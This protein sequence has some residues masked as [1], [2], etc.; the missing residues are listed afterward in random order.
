[1]NP[2]STVVYFYVN[3]V[4]LLAFHGSKGQSVHQCV[5]RF[6]HPTR[7]PPCCE[8]AKGVPPSHYFQVAF[9]QF[10]RRLAH[11]FL[12]KVDT[13]TTLS[14]K[15]CLQAVRNYS[16]VFDHLPVG[17]RVT[18]GERTLGGRVV[19]NAPL[20]PH[21]NS[22]T[23]SQIGGDPSCCSYLDQTSINRK[24]LTF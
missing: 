2:Y 20:K 8:I 7:Q 22:L 12:E 17:P 11:S 24:A 4:V 19:G 13:T 14:V 1:M 3:I 16:L 10:K 6:L 23:P 5:G 21:L 18:L 9:A 15:L